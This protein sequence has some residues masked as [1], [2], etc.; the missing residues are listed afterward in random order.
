[1]SP[2]LV[3]SLLTSCLSPETVSW[4][5]DKVLTLMGLPPQLGRQRVNNGY[6]NSRC[7]ECQNGLNSGESKGV[8]QRKEDDEW[9][10]I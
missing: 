9:Q 1:M 5:K 3:G 6:S 2:A 10:Q 7:T 8:E 4:A